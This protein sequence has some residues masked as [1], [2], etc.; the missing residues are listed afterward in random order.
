MGR[1]KERRL[2]AKAASG[3][4]VKLDLFLDASPGDASS[5]EGVGGENREQ[6][7]GVPTSP[8]S[9]D[10]KENPLALLGQYSD[11]EEEDDGAGAQPNGE[12]NGSPTNAS[13]EV[14]HERD[15]TAGDNDVVHSEPPASDSGQ[16]VAPQADGVN[17]FTENVAE[18]ITAAPEPTPENGC[19]TETEAIPD[20]SGMQ[21]VG[22]I[23][24]NWKTVMHEQSNQ[25]YYWNTVTGETSWE[26]PNGL[27]PGVVAD[28]VTSAS[29]PTHVEYSIEAQAHVPHS[30][31]EAY[32]SDVS[33]GNGTSAYTAM[34][35]V[36]ARGQLTQ[37][38]YAYTGAV[39]SHESMD[40]DPLRLAKYG[41]DLL[42]RLKLLERPHGAI[43]SL[44]LI[45]REIEI[46]VS[47]CNVLSSY[48]SSLLPLWLH[49]EV[50]LKQL[51]FSV[52]KFEA[53]YTAYTH[54]ETEHAEYKAPNEAEILAPSD[55]EG[56]KFE[57]ITVVPMDENLKVE[58]PCSTA[59]VQ[60]S[61]EKDAAAV[62]SRV[63]PDCDE[64]MDVEME[65]DE[66]NVEDQ[67]CSSSMPNEEH[68]SSEQ[69]RSPTL[70]SLEKSAPPPEDNDIPPPPPPEE[71][72]IPPPPPENEPAPPPPPEP[73]ETTVVSYVHTD[74]LTQSYVDQANF[75][76]ALPGMEYY[77]AAVSAGGISIPVDA[78]SIPPVPG[79]YYSYPS[80]TMDAS[81][82]AAESSGYYASSTSTISSSALD[83]KTTSAPIDA[84][85]S[86]VNPIESDKVISKEAK[87]AS[88]SQA[89]GA[90]SASG[91]VRG[92]ST[93]ASTSTTNQTKVH[94]TKKRPVAVASSLR[95]N[96]KVS[97]LV[98]KWKAAKEELRDEE[99]EEPEDALEALEKKR[100]K[101]IDGWRKQQIA[102]GEAKENANFVPLGGDWRDRVKRRRAEAKKESKSEF[103]QAVPEQHKGQ[104]DLVE[105]SKG[106]PS[107]WQAYIDESTKQVYYG[108]NLTSETTWDRPTK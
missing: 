25:C 82:V 102:S 16:Q 35:M 13:V 104:P 38:A 41:E 46:R 43:D 32:P 62:T 47:D 24:G 108:N 92:S 76:Y 9:S 66:E 58:E 44:E 56:L 5:K 73:E 71:E 30:N 17:N 61:E 63:E 19:V 57:V 31:V 72:W 75:G 74:T 69:V 48:G 54:P 86:D 55:A 15:N 103:I 3:R 70:P 88:L 7:S 68:H 51:E 29:I 80:V 39:A 45:K 52:S 18:Q 4:R 96:K 99:E 42:Q 79:S 100:R 59:S 87:I 40:I 67:G 22:D 60:N 64:D 107:G 78:A 36:C 101:E 85:N 10:K 8:S 94:R 93:Q 34:G 53:S 28:G 105:L 90:T 50:H 37:N 33:I 20:S 83:N 27:A 1:R 12:A 11:D 26:I 6:Q 65:V 77:P 23:G 21:I 95:S 89:V 91:T 2:A 84:T 49:A 106:L 98:D 97:S 14:T 81:G